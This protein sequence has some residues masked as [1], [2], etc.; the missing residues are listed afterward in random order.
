MH[1]TLRRHSEINTLLSEH[2]LKRV[3]FT[4]PL[5]RL[6]E[7]LQG[8]RM[9]DLQR[10]HA[11]MDLM[12]ENFGIID[13]FWD[14][15]RDQ[16]L[17]HDK[18]MGAVSSFVYGKAFAS[19]ETIIK[20]YNMFVSIRSALAMQAPRRFGKTTAIAIAVVVIFMSVP[21]C[22]IC[23][24]AQSSRSAG[25]DSGIL[26]KIKEILK[27]CF[28]FTAFEHCNSEDVTARFGATDLRK[29]HALSGKSGDSYVSFLFS[30]FTRGT[31]FRF[32]LD[33]Y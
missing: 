27:K 31:F 29:I 12:R 21:N 22:E 24:V 19:N 14:R 11:V 15:S 2:A 9:S 4:S 5:T 26:G 16:R 30:F 8:E 7:F 3:K 28:N 33:G 6:E 1:S 32:L 13:E 17:I 25:T 20:Q 10:G 18:I 23:I